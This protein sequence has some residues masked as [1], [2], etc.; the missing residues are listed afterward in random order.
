MRRLHAFLLWAV[1]AT[2]VLLSWIA[3]LFPKEQAL[4]HASFAPLHQLKKLL[5]RKID[6]AHLLLGI[7]ENG[8]VLRVP[9]TEKRKELG[10]VL[11]D[12]RTRGGKGL[13]GISQ[14]LSWTES[15]I[16]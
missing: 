7:G 8:Q 5:S 16:I 3:G 9:A 4:F 11:V 14:I 13:F 1:Q 2:P 6:G 15:L 12:S 10:N